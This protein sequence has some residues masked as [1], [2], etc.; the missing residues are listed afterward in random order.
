MEGATLYEMLLFRVLDRFNEDAHYGNDLDG[1]FHALMSDAW[2]IL[3]ELETGEPTDLWAAYL[4][5]EGPFKQALRDKGVPEYDLERRWQYYLKGVVVAILGRHGKLDVAPLGMSE[6][7]K[8][9]L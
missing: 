8:D 5:Q 9:Y 4:D 7:G 3:Y 2:R 1:D 6:E